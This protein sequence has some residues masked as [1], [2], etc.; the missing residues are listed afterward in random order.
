MIL[1]VFIY[2]SFKTN[3]LFSHNDPSNTYQLRV[4][5]MKIGVPYEAGHQYENRV[6]RTS[7]YASNITLCHFI[8]SEFNASG[9]SVF[10]F[11]FFWFILTSF[12]YR[13]ICRVV[14]I[15]SSDVSSLPASLSS[16]EQFYSYKASSPLSQIDFSSQFTTTSLSPLFNS[17]QQIT[18]E[19]SMQLPILP[20]PQ[21][22]MPDLPKYCISTIW[23][24]KEGEGR[25][26]V[27]KNK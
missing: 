13:S 25:T 26:G 17:T 12:T 27:F 24:G 6:F 18:L 8:A 9:Y 19:L 11:F 3:F 2:L 15:D 16:L 21:S 1:S 10:L 22:H 14:T 20:I 5:A 7:G 23:E 4:P